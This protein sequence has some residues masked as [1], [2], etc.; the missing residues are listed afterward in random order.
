MNT[1]FPRNN[2]RWSQSFQIFMYINI[3]S[4][5]FM[6]IIASHNNNNIPQPVSQSRWNDYVPKWLLHAKYHP[7]AIL[8]M[9][10]KRDYIFCWKKIPVNSRGF[11]PIAHSYLSRIE[12]FLTA[13]QTHAH[14]FISPREHVKL[15][16]RNSR[17]IYTRYQ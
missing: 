11:V 6:H 13:I 7:S 17:N 5:I 3:V 8:I 14:T 12:F 2:G 9:S 15:I 4:S 10:S 1:S 16:T